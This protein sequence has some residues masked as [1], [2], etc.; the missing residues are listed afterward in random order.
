M[1]RFIVVFILI[2]HTLISYA[3]QANRNI[4]VVDAGSS[5]TRLCLYKISNINP[6]T[7]PNIKL[8]YKTDISHGITQN[9][10]IPEVISPIINNL[11]QYLLTVNIE[12]KN[13][14]FYLYATGGMRALNDHQKE[15]QIYKTIK[16]YLNTATKFHNYSLKTISGNDEALFAWLD[17]NYLENNFSNNTTDGI[18]DLGGA[19]F[20]IAYNSI[21]SNP[22]SIRIKLKNNKTYNLLTYSVQGYG[23]NLMNKKMLELP[24]K[25][26]CFPKY[27]SITLDLD[28]NFN[29]K[30]CDKN[31]QS[32]LPDFKFNIPD[33][34]NFIGISGISYNFE[35]F[36]IPNM[37]SNN[38]IED[39]INKICSLDWNIMQNSYPHIPKNYL[40]NYCA[41]TTYTKTL[42]NNI[43]SSQNNYLPVSVIKTYNEEAVTWTRGAVLYLYGLK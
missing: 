22:E 4:I 6:N 36:N 10:L 16:D 11:K 26:A 28:G 43:L 7:I 40:A 33:N 15:Q 12:E 24:S 9:N 5:G 23:M 42:L 2:F 20:Q 8:I 19:S 39:N 41:N 32:L 30:K 37:P 13:I 35:F 38:I 27:Y 1:T 34:I 25:T 3:G 14:D 17:I 21:S 18:I 31:Y 29:L